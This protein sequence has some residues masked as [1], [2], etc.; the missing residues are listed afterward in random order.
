MDAGGRVNEEK[1][2]DQ[3]KKLYSNF[4]QDFIDEDT[5]NNRYGGR[6]HT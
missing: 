3:D 1:S 6:V 5:E 4:I 2:L